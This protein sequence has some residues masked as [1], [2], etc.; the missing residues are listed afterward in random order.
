MNNNA[1]YSAIEAKHLEFADARGAEK[2]YCPSEVAR[3]LFPKHWRDKM[4]DVRAVADDLFKKDILIISQFG[5][6]LKTLPTKVKGHIRL[7]KNY[8]FKK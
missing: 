6:D 7:R 5:K 4:D 2:T 1:E 3:H 8:K